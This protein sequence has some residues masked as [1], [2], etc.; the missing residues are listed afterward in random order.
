M[1]A[2]SLIF[3]RVQGEEKVFFNKNKI[4]IIIPKREREREMQMVHICDYIVLVVQRGDERCVGNVP[5]MHCV[6]SEVTSEVSLALDY[7]FQQSFLID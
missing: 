3:R 6:L 1:T 7:T 4:L 5:A 2:N